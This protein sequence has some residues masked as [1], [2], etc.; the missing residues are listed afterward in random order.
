MPVY[1]GENFVRQAIESILNQTYQNLE[2]LIADDGSKDRT[3]QIV[4]SYGSDKIKT[5]RFKKNI[6]AF[7]RTNFLIK[8]AK[9]KYLALMD[10]D[11]VSHGDRIKTQ[12]D[13]LKNKTDV[14]VVGSQVNVINEE[15]EIIGK[16]NLPNTHADIYGQFGFIHPMVHPSCMMRKSLLP[17]RKSLYFTDF[18]VNSDYHTFIELLRYGQFANLPDALLNYRVHA[19]NSSLSN[20]KHYFINTLKIRWLAITRYGYQMSLKAIILTLCQI[21][22]LLFLPQGIISFVYPFVRGI[23]K[24]QITINKPLFWERKVAIA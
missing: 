11:D 15:G 8:H 19:R 17:K 3:W 21:P 23:Y 9:G 5:F 22:S 4:T 24:P 2:L 18:G 1:N 6:G 12:I 14:I 13:F 16:K 7:P 20:L 10:S